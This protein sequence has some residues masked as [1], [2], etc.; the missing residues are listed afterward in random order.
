MNGREREAEV[1]DAALPSG[2]M[3]KV[4]VVEGA[5]GMGSVGRESLDLTEALAPIGEVAAL[6]QEKLE[7]LTAKRASV[8]FGVSLAVSAGKLTALLF[9][10]KAEASLTVTL[11]WERQAG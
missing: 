2:A 4:R 3:V 5:A 10:G 7:S 8:E 1:V 6:V 9:D 11:D